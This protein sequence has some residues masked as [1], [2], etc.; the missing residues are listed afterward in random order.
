MTDDT[1][2]VSQALDCR[3]DG[4]QRDVGM[5]FAAREFA[6]FTAHVERSEAYQPAI[7]VSIRPYPAIAELYALRNVILQQS[8]HE[9][10][11]E[12]PSRECVKLRAVQF[13]QGRCQQ[14]RR[15]VSHTPL[16]T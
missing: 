11:R 4:K 1:R 3:I 8:S 2:S 7:R 15:A 5:E 10:I 14:D 13:D 12:R 6:A 9:W 16:A